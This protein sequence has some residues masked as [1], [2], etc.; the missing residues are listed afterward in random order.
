MINFVMQVGGT[1]R[2]AGD[3]P[4]RAEVGYGTLDF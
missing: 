1:R 3:Y 2:R 4:C